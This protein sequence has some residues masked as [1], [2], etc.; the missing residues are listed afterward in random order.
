VRGDG[1]VLIGGGLK[2]RGIAR[3]KID[4]SFDPGFNPPQVVGPA[5]INLVVAPMDG[6]SVGSGGFTKGNLISRV[7]LGRLNGDGTLDQSFNP[8]IGV[9]GQI[10]AMVL[11]SDGKLFAVGFE[12]NP[13][14]RSG[15]ARF[16]P[17]GALDLSFHP[18]SRLDGSGFMTCAVQSNGQLLIAGFNRNG[19]ARLNS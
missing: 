13:K 5:R 3:L 15:I 16:N 9:S 1:K 7:G 17:D 14:S 12:V 19:L 18:D 10:N 2:P 4:G 11:Q 6:K 8:D